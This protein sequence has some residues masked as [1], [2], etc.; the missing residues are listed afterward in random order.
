MQEEEENTSF[1]AAILGKIAWVP[2]D[3]LVGPQTIGYEVRN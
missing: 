3:S 2:R 1:L